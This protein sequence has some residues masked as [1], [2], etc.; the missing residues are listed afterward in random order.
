V[1]GSQVGPVARLEERAEMFLFR[2]TD[3][4]ASMGTR[5]PRG[6]GFERCWCHGS[7]LRDSVGAVRM[8]EKLLRASFW[9]Q[10]WERDMLRDAIRA[11]KLDEGC[12]HG[13]ELMA[14]G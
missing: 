11:L 12:N 4:T 13:R 10:V 3:G 6:P 9:I 14:V 5:L 7:R 2:E 8:G 1:A